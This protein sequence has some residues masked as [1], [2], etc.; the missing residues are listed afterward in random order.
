MKRK[1]KLSEFRA[2]SNEETKNSFKENTEMKRLILA[3]LL[4]IV[5]I[6]PAM[7]A[8]YFNTTRTMVTD[9]L[10]QISIK[11]VDDGDHAIDAYVIPG[12]IAGHLMDMITDPGSPSPTALY[13]ITVTQDGR[14]LLGGYGA[15]RSATVT[16]SIRDGGFSLAEANGPATLNITNNSVNSAQFGIRFFVAK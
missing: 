10:E 4:A 1:S 3:C 7:A 6:S 15:D 13:D 12:G 11:I 14:D 5:L 16:E 2:R 8:D 9:R